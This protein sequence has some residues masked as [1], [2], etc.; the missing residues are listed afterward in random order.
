MLLTQTNITLLLLSQRIAFFKIEQQ[1]HIRRIPYKP[2]AASKTPLPTNADQ[3]TATSSKRSK[4]PPLLSET[5]PYLVIQSSDL[6]RSNVKVAYSN[7][8]IQCYLK[9]NVIKVSF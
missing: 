7:I 9:D 6:I 3:P 1:L 8:A 4:K 2:V 5:S